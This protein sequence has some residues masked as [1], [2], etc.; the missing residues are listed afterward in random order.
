M[1]LHWLTFMGLA[2]FPALA[3]AQQALLTEPLRLFLDCQAGCDFDYLRQ[4][5]PFVSHVRDRADAQIHVLITA[6][7]TGSGGRRYLLNFIGNARFA[8]VSDT[9]TYTAAES[10][11]PELRR[12]GLARSI[13][14][15][16][17]RFVAAT[18]QAQ[19]IAI[20]FQAPTEKA[21]T[22]AASTRDPWNFWV[23][24]VNGNGNMN[25]EQ[26]QSNYSVNT[27]LRASRTTENWKF[28]IQV[29]GRYSE[30]RY[31]LSDSS[32]YV[33]DSRNYNG[34]ALLVKSVGN[35]ISMGVE[36]RANSS[37]FSNERIAVRMAPALELSYYPY[38]EAT[39]RQLSLLYSVGVRRV[40]Y[41]S[42]TLFDKTQETLANERL[43]LSYD[44]QQPW[45]EAGVSLTGSH[46]FHDPKLHRLEVGAG[47]ELRLFRGVS[48]NFGGE[49]SRIR[50]QIGLPKE[51]ASD[52]DVLVQ[53]QQLATGYEYGFHMGLSYSFGSIFNNVVNPRFF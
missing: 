2:V 47:L 6:Q 45:G 25:G 41:H 11:T 50:D 13:K 52:E 37:I 29:N 36:A 14:M 35:H 27:S 26:S 46:Y 9:L 1:K 5:I 7:G 44:V 34:N 40:D 33:A 39:R 43:T 21:S 30:S 16:I 48:L 3:Q 51:D 53:R 28:N 23:F 15:G 4:E 22:Q 20:S 8:G 12:R 31:T 18:P 17:M 24:R 49:Y 10:D 19:G 32:E 42:E 38:E